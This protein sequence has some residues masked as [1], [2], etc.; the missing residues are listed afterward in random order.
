M[1]SFLASKPV[2]FHRLGILVGC[3]GCEL[4][5]Q[6]SGWEVGCRAQKI[7]EEINP[8]GCRF[9]SHLPSSRSTKSRHL[10][11]WAGLLTSGSS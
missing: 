5:E 4:G 8:R 3:P 9:S 2:D 1:N 10:K 7:L 6:T 11:S